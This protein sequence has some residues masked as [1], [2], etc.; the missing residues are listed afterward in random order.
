MSRL[1]DMKGK[2]FHGC[3]VI[4]RA[5]SNRDGKATWKCRCVCGNVFI[6]TGKDIRN[7]STKSCGCLKTKVIVEAGL[8]NVTHGETKT[9][10]YGIWRGMKKRCYIPSDISYKNYGA[11]GITVCNEWMG[12]YEVFRDWAMANGYQ[13][14]LT[15]DRINSA[16]N[17][18]PE[19]CRWAD[20]VTQ[21]RNRTNNVFVNFRGEEMTLSQVAEE[22]GESKEMIWYRHKHGIDFNLPNRLKESDL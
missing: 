7:G 19:N 21:A 16:G 9:R 10:L 13:E 2:K 11:K 14:H 5:G 12:S 17:Y 20:W 1:I 4:Y 18:T 22:V 3:V 15:L 8:R 6:A